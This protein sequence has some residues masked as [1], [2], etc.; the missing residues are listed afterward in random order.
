[1][2]EK[3]RKVSSWMRFAL[4]GGAMLVAGSS[5]AFSRLTEA[6][7]HSKGAHVSFVVDSAPVQRDGKAVMSFAPVV[8]QV[9]PSV[10]KVFTTTKAKQQ[11]MPFFDDPM[12]RRFFGDE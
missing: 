7:D 6:K 2:K 8:K 9:A 4:L 3:I 1:M 5:L 11:R 12:F 10:V